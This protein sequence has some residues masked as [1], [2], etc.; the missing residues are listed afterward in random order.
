MS[1]LSAE[2]AAWWSSIH[3]SAGRAVL[4]VEVANRSRM[5]QLSGCEGRSGNRGQGVGRSCCGLMDSELLI[6]LLEILFKDPDLFL[7]CAQ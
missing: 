1:F 3:L 2:E 4:L 7:Y 5:R 6:G